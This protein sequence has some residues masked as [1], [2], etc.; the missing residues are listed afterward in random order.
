MKI[1]AISVFSPISQLLARK[2]LF[3]GVIKRL[4]PFSLALPPEIYRRSY[5]HKQPQTKSAFASRAEFE[6]A[7]RRKRTVNKFARS[8]LF[9][10]LL[11]EFAGF[12]GK[13]SP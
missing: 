9:W 7:T 3:C 1:S 2:S 5:C 4:C 13:E 10:L 8:T 11:I 12:L 6:A